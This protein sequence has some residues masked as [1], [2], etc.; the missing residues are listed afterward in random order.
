MIK[1]IK[2]GKKEFHTTCP[3]CGCEFTYEMEDLSGK[4]YDYIGVS[5]YVKCPECGTPIS[6]LTINTTPTPKPID[7]YYKDTVTDNMQS[8]N[9]CANCSYIKEL[10][11]DHVYV[12]DTPCTWCEFNPLKVTYTTVCT[13]TNTNTDVSI[14]T[15]K[16][17]G[18]EITFNNGKN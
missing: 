7:I 8:N 4:N 10:M 9:P 1:I 2:S 17:E 18:G 15:G 12:G 3:N 11:T 13:A 6:H 14:D 16:T 5:N